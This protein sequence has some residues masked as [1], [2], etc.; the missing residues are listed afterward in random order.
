MMGGEGDGPRYMYLNDVQIF[1][2]WAW[3]MGPPLHWLCVAMSAVV[4]G[5]LVFVV[6]GA[7][8]ERAVCLPTSLT[9]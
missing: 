8:M 4:H 1:D 7:D 3:N 5:D 2:G 6:G 9:W